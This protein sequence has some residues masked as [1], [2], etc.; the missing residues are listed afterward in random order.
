MKLAVTVKCY[1]E[2]HYAPCKV[3]LIHGTVR[4]S[5]WY[6]YAKYQGCKLVDMNFCERA[7]FITG[8]LELSPR[9]R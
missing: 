6:C 9:D 1:G 7:S 8:L 4:D 3:I 2:K 5:W